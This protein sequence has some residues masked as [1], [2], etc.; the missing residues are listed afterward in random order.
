MQA[1][2]QRQ[3]RDP[4]TSNKNTQFKEPTEWIKRYQWM[5]KRSWNR[6]KEEMIVRVT[7]KG[8]TDSRHP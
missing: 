6:R 1:V 8:M 4:D 2:N 3:H 7:Y 5:L